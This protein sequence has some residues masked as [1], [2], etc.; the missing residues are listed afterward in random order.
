MGLWVAYFDCSG[1]GI[2]GGFFLREMAFEDGAGFLF[3]EN[4]GVFG[5]MGA[6]RGFFGGVRRMARGE[7][8]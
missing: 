2:S 6:R 7:G 4:S 3:A 5:G 8:R 1:V